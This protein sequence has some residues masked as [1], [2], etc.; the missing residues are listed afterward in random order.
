MSYTILWDSTLVKEKIEELF[1]L[2]T[3]LYKRVILTNYLD[4]IL[5]T[6]LLDVQNVNI[7]CYPQPGNIDPYALENLKKRGA[8]IYLSSPINSNIFYVENKG[9]LLGSA[10]FNYTKHVI[11]CHNKVKDIMIYINDWNSI[12][13]NSIINSLETVLMNESDLIKFKEEHHIF[14]RTY[15][16]FEEMIYSLVNTKNYINLIEDTIKK[17]TKKRHIINTIIDFLFIRKPKKHTSLNIDNKSTVNLKNE[18]KETINN[19]TNQNKM[20]IYCMSKDD[21]YEML[22]NQFQ[23][24][25]RK[26][27]KKI[28]H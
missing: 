2:N 5:P 15:D 26:N 16:G 27:I 11:R 14:W 12:D 28:V 18:M 6:M 24:N 13:I 9:I 23:E 17:G 1:N 22:S 21:L 3:R 7:F 4:E 25:K 10:N 8:T 19:H 20:N